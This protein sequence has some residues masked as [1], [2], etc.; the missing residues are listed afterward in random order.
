[1]IPQ[2]KYLERKR[3]EYLEEHGEYPDCA[4]GCGEKVTIGSNGKPNLYAGK[5][6]NSKANSDALSQANSSRWTA[7]NTIPKQDL[8]AALD[9][10]RKQKGWTWKQVAAESG[11]SY[12]TFMN[13]KYDARCGVVSKDWATKLIQRLGGVGTEPTKHEKR[14]AEEHVKQV[15]RA[16]TGIGMDPK[17]PKMKDPT[18][19]WNRA[20]RERYVRD[21]PDYKPDRTVGDWY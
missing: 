3:Q 1:M 10:L 11:H 14:T 17:K 8:F 6:H 18:F 20:A 13:I 9:K 12:R 16:I 19:T 5:G 4:C 15:D 2:Q 21:N 7:E